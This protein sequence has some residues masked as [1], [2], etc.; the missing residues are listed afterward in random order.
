MERPVLDERPESNL[1]FHGPCDKCGSSDARAVYDD[2]HSYC[3]ACPSD[4]AY[5][6][7][8]ELGTKAPTT[9]ADGLLPT[10]QAQALGKRKLTEETCRK[11][12]YTVGE[13]HGRS[14]QIANYIRDGEIVAQKVRFPD[15]TF[16]F[17]GDTKNSGLY[18]QHLWKGGGKKL[19]ICEGEIDALTVSQLQDNKWP[20]VSIPNGAAGAAKSIRKELEFVS[21]FD[22]VVIMFDMDEAGQAAA[23][24]VASLLRPG[25]AKIATLSKKD[26][27]ELH[28]AGL[29][30]SV[31]DA[32]WQAKDYRPDGI[33]NA[34]DLWEKVRLPKHVG[35]PYPW[36]A[37]TKKTY[38]I[39]KGELVVLTAGSGVGK[40]AVVREIT[41]DLLNKGHC[42][43]MLMLE[44]SVERTAEGFVGLHLNKPIHITRDGVTEEQ[45]KEAFDATTGSG[46]LWLYDHFGSVSAGNLLDRIRYLA[47]GCQCDFVILDH[48]S[49]A[50]SDSTANDGEDERKLIDRLMTQLRSLVEELKIG[51]FVIS[52][53]RRPTGDRGHEQGAMTSLSQLRGSHAIAQ[54]ADFVIGL[55]RNQQDEETRNQ[56]TIRVLKNRFSGDTGEAG[57]LYYD[58]LTGRLNEHDFGGVDA[59]Y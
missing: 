3:F 56:T 7:G 9:K 20:V 41:Y 33:I 39:R 40:S 47:V 11:F 12:R 15:K 35:I 44:E 58:P 28:Q 25:Q 1:M 59:G 50:V 42:I 51:L 26:P 22:E 43:G 27:S 14:V 23:K 2:G 49:I 10:G 6:K 16:K 31:I 24:E 45:L 13:Y 19:V 30:R 57:T 18:G 36:E 37:L 8:N 4:T 38:G 34:A 32:I 55:E 53:L 54:L 46:R 21:S 17:L 52:H 48:I 5:Q 29:G